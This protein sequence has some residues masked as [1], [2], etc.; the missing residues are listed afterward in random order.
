V[1]GPAGREPAILALGVAGA[2][3][4]VEEP[5]VG[6]AGVISL[7]AVEEPPVAGATASSRAMMAALARLIPNRLASWRWLTGFPAATDAARAARAADSASAAT[8]PGATAGTPRDACLPVP[9]MMTMS[10]SYEPTRA[11]AG[12][13]ATTAP[14]GPN[15]DPAATLT[16][17]VAMIPAASSHRASAGAGTLRWAASSNAMLAA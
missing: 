16:A 14:S 13:A 7:A 5:V 17:R 3:A 2:L 10:S 15:A 6:V 11:R 8:R 12:Q 1:V 9:R 4:I